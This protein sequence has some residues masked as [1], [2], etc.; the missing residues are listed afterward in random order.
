MGVHG[1]VG[2]VGTFV[3]VRVHAA[4]RAVDDHVILL[5]RVCSDVTVLNGPRLFVSADFHRLQ[6]KRLQAEVNGFRRTAGT[7]D[8]RFLME[9]L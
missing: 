3:S 7:E 1:V 4:G 6:S 9:M 5:N 8:E 2:E